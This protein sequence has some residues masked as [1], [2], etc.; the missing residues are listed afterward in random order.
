[1]KITQALTLSCIQTDQR[2]NT[3]FISK[4]RVEIINAVSTLSNLNCAWLIKNNSYNQNNAC[5]GRMYNEI[6]KLFCLIKNLS[7]LCK[8]RF[9]SNENG[10]SSAGEA[11]F[12]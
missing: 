8:N 7:K 9:V 10:T 4:Q 6:K 1:M 12:L 2:L 3:H 11:K 5:N